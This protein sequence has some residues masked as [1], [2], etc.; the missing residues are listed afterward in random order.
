VGTSF[1]P[2]YYRKA[3]TDETNSKEGYMTATMTTDVLDGFIT[4]LKKQD[5]DFVKKPIRDSI[6]ELQKRVYNCVKDSADEELLKKHKEFVRCCEKMMYK[7][8]RK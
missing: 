5:S 3:V 2:T 8:K 1:P 6:C 7:R 4:N